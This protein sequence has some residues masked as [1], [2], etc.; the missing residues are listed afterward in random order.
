[1]FKIGE[2]SKLANVSIRSLR[3]YDKIGILIPERIDEETNYRHYSA[4]QLQT[5]NKIQK[6]KEIGLSLSV[7]KE[8]LASDSDTKTI[9][10]HF[11]IRELELQEE[12]VTIQQQSR[13][14]ESS[15]AFLKEDSLKLNYHI[16]KKEIPTRYVASIRDTIPSFASEGI[17]WERLYQE[18]MPGQAQVAKEPYNMAIFHDE[19]YQDVN[20]DVEIQ[21]SVQR[22]AEHA[23]SSP[24]FKEAPAIDVASVIINGSYEQITAVTQTVASWMENNKYQLNGPMFNIYHVSIATEPN[25]ENWV[26]EA[27]FPIKESTNEI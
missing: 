16:V 24:I 12:L 15:L 20:V 27:C 11:A 1:M 9:Q 14:L 17:L 21:V 2:F 22:E 5:I 8:I 18:M 25:P 10:S 26:T 4:I 19:S 13:L 23:R 7:I 6:L 3:H